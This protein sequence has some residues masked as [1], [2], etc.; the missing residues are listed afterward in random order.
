MQRP[1]PALVLFFGTGIIIA[2]FYPP[3]P[4]SRAITLLLILA[5]FLILTG[6]PRKK[7]TIIFIYL[8]LLV[9]GI[10]AGNLSLSQPSVGHHISHYVS[11][12]VKVHGVVISS[13]AQEDN[14]FRLIVDARRVTEGPTQRNV[15][16][17]F[18]LSVT[19]PVTKLC[20]GDYIAV[21]TTLR[22]PR[23]FQN[24]GCFDYRRHLKSLGIYVRAS[25]SRP[26]DIAVL[27][28][29]R[30]NI[31][32]SA[33]DHYRSYLRRFINKHCPD[34]ARYLIR[35]LTVGDNK[36]LPSHI[37]QFFS[38]A[39]VAHVLA[40]SGL[41]VGM[42]AVIAYALVVFI[43]NRS[44]ALLL[45]YNRK[46]VASC[47]SILPV[48]IYL[49]VAGFQI[50]TV[51]ASIM[52]LACLW[53]VLIDRSKDTLNILAAAAF[54]I[55]VVSPLS[56]YNIS[57][58]LSFLSVFTIIITTPVFMAYYTRFRDAHTIPFRPLA[59]RVATSV[60]V[61]IS[62]V[63]GTAPLVAYHFNYFSTMSLLSN[64][65]IVPIVGFILLPVLLLFIVTA[66][67]FPLLGI[68]LLT[69]ASTF[70]SICLQ[71]VHFIAALPLSSFMVITPT[72][73]SI[74]LYYLI[75]ITTIL[76][77]SGYL[78]RRRDR[79]FAVTMLLIFATLFS[80]NA[81]YHKWFHH[82]PGI[83]E[84]TFIDVGHGCA[85][86]LR[87]PDGK[88]ML[89]DGGGFYDDSFDI[90]K[91]VVSPFLLHEG[92]AKIDVIVLTHPHQ[93][94]IGGLPYI[95]SHF[96]VGEIWSNGENVNTRSYTSFIEAIK[97]KGIPHRFVSHGSPSRYFGD[98]FVNVINPLHRCRSSMDTQV[99][100]DG[101]ENAVVLFIRF[102]EHAFL[103]SSDI[104]RNTE[105][106]IVNECNLESC[107]ILQVP[108]HGSR[109]SSSVRYLEN[110][111]P[112]V[113]VCSCGPYRPALFPHPRIVE[114]Y[115]RMN[116]P[117][118]RT[119]R[120]G[121]VTVTTDGQSFNISSF[122]GN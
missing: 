57:F 106:R 116:I 12:H 73:S 89:V 17:R 98:S 9:L 20:Y 65:V 7:T 74:I 8:S 1:F 4:P 38:T 15:T 111:S 60:C 109:Y 102:G 69:I 32:F 2:G 61:T 29:H 31:V 101:N 27:R 76:L 33:V 67:V 122:N 92:V 68:F 104:S 117:L 13:F 78:S 36:A 43:L 18:L 10:L 40:I 93:D 39:G 6:I 14:K 58:Q 83:L 115:R 100:H 81:V 56:L 21:C 59:D 121:A 3:S 16:G 119:D 120:D 19:N 37:R 34:P 110:A 70:S 96:A 72:P 47:L 112:R 86:F 26:I 79:I 41:H 55:L 51:R 25:V 54:V 99:A 108:H 84:A 88:T 63:A 75:F 30:G 5:A 11:R 64:F 85:T 95:I 22:E 53:A 97:T 71:L 66:H 103:L 24:P 107:T 49:F 28:H 82:K 50:S 23:N 35:A 46:K 42:I 80:G 52:V 118:L 87:L 45:T 90:G 62:A 77:I 105:A 91:Y 94:H 114:R 48:V 113:A 44:E